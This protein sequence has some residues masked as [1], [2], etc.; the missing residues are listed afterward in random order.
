MKSFIFLFSLLLYSGMVFCQ[1]V[2]TGK[3]SESGGQIISLTGFDGFHSYELVSSK[4]AADGSFTLNYPNSYVGMAVLNVGEQESLVLVLEEGGVEIQG[5][6]ISDFE[7]TK[8]SKGQENLWFSTYASEQ[9]KR[10][11]ALNVW[12]YL[13]NVYND[14]LFSKQTKPIQLFAAE[15][16]RIKEEGEA[17]LAVLPDNSYMKWYLPNRG[18]IANVENIVMN[19]PSEIPDAI[20]QFRS[21]DFTDKR[22]YTSGILNEAIESHVRL[23]ENSSG[24][25]D[26]VYA[27]LNRS[28]DILIEKLKL[29]PVLFNTVADKLFMYLEKRS[30]FRSAE[31]LALKLL[32]T[33]VCDLESTFTDKLEAYRV[34]RKGNTAAD[35]EFGQNTLLP[36]GV[37]A[38]KLSDLNSEFTLVVFAAGWCSHCVT[39]IPKLTDKYHQ[40]KNRGVEIVLFS[41]DN[42]VEDFRKFAENLPFIRTTD[43]K[44]WDGKVAQEYHVYGTPTMYL[45]NKDRQI[46]VNIKSPEHMDA[47]VN[48]TDLVRESN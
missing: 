16:Q 23:I 30:L 36:P 3:L 26:S 20:I 6:T 34:M 44:M 28:T 7:R 2:L 9:P 46:L 37:K 33:N 22:W 8:I 24:E 5:T 1:T 41:L 39:L 21:L 11:R 19:L 14:S 43:L 29:E 48:N 17:F 27:E 47:W 18:L 10:E 4:V 32:N 35:I 13:Q 42:T 45:L 15:I 31:Y 38:S 25:L 40:W 12:R